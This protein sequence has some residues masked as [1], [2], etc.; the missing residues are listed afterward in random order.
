MGLSLHLGLMT[1]GVSFAGNF[2]QA[3]LLSVLNQPYLEIQ[4][5]LPF[6]CETQ[7]FV[8][9]DCQNT[10]QTFVPTG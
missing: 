9:T 4:Q 3:Y 10:V 8:A 5:V 7:I 6:G 1:L 2:Q